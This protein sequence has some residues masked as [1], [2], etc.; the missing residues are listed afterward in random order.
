[1]V[2]IPPPKYRKRRRAKA[3]ANQPTPPGAPLVLVSA[4]WEVGGSVTVTFDRAVDLSGV[5][6][7][8]LVVND[9]PT[10]FTYQGTSVLDH[11]TPETAVVEC[12]GVSEYEGP[13]VVLNVSAESGIVAVDDGGTWA[14]VTD[15]ELPY[16]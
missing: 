2:S 16:P 11:P 10:G 4:S 13:G 9:G 8:A 6:P 5:V 1:M 15:L 3:K 12:S 7:G 14:G